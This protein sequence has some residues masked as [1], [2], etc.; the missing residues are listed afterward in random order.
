M[1]DMLDEYARLFVLAYYWPYFLAGNADNL[2]EISHLLL[3][4]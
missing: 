3:R 2:K 4:R 1:E